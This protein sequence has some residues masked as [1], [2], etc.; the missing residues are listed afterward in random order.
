MSASGRS[1]TRSSEPVSTPE[2][3]GLTRNGIGV[4][5]LGYDGV[6][7]AHIHAVLRLAT[8]FWPPPF[9]PRLVALAGRSAE[10]VREAAERYGALTAYTDWRGLVEDER[11]DVLI[12]AT[13]NDVHVEA[14][15]AAVHRGLHVLC[16]KPLARSAEEAG[17][18]RD[19]AVAAGVVHMTGFN[20]RFVPAVQLA[21]RLIAAGRIGE[22]YHF[23]TRYC[24]DSMVDPR[25]PYGW[26]HS[27]AQAGSGVIGDLAA[28]ALD[29]AR[30]LTGE[31]RAVSA[32]SRIFIDRRPRRGGGEGVVDVEDALEA[33]VEFEGGA[34]GTLEASTFCPGRKNLLT[35]EVNGSRG[36]LMFNLERLNE[37]DAFFG[38]DTANGFR[39]V[40]VTETAHPYGG[41]WWPPGHLLG[42]ENVFVHQLQCFFQ[43][44]AEG[45]T[46][47]PDGASFEDGYRC[48]VVCDALE[49][50][51]REGHRR[52]IE[53]QV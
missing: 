47:A 53:A 4:G 2:R 40:I 26:R 20:Y 19:A 16:E 49:Q 27:K 34:I 42:W 37:L 48:A 52:T 33:V 1:P 10:R 7:K 44:I 21:R 46:V 14:S 15:L 45:K 39:T 5:V 35:F 38:D 51:A 22:V 11:I 29:L 25:V 43:A 17:V 50:A 9:H 30:Y 8:V 41:T 24:D 3:R 6:A 18:L 13:P 36:S 32:A 23:R 12:N 31:V 28:H